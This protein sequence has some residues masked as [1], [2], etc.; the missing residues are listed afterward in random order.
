MKKSALYLVFILL[1]VSL[2]TFA[3]AKI[4]I[5]STPQEMY[6]LGDD[7]YI[8]VTTIPASN[9]GNL[10]VNLNCDNL[11]TNIL[12]WPVAY[13]G[14]QYEY[15]LPVKT[16][17]K[18]DMEVDSVEE[19]IGNCHISATLG[20]EQDSTNNFV[21]TRDILIDASLNKVKYNP[22]EKITL[23][24]TAKKANGDYLNGVLAVSGATSFKKAVAEGQAIDSFTLPETTEA[25][26]YELELFVYDT[27]RGEVIMNSGN[28]SLLFSINQIADFIEVVLSDIEA[29]PGNDFSFSTNIYDQSGKQMDG[30]VNVLASSSN[31]EEFQTTLQSGS[32][33][34]VKLPFNATSGTW[35]IRASLKDIVEEREFS[36]K[37]VQKVY[38]EFLDSI[39]IVKNI[40]NDIYNKT[41]EVRIGDKLESLDV[42]ILPGEER[43]FNLKAPKGEYVVLV[44]DGNDSLEKSLLLTGGAV[45]IDNVGALGWFNKYPTL[46]L[47]IIFILCVVTGFFLYKYKRRTVKSI[48][49]NDEEEVGDTKKPNKTKKI[50]ID[51]N[52][53]KL[54][55]AEANAAMKG[56]KAK[57]TVVSLKLS[58]YNDFK[59]PTKQEFDKILSSCVKGTKGMVDFRGEY[60]FI[61]YS[62]V[63]TK[64]F[65]NEKTAAKVAFE[66]L[67]KMTEYNRKFAEKMEFN[68]GMNS[69]DL[70]TSLD[71]K[72]KLEYTSVG[73]TILL[74]KRI[75]DLGKAK[76]FVSE[77]VKL[78][79]GREFKF[80]K[81][82]VLGKNNIYSVEDMQD[83]RLDN[84]KLANIL[85]RIER[86]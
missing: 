40:G 3:S 1:L 42:N 7:I 10:N 82:G 54:G 86:D 51:I 33:G 47:V 85:K 52:K 30:V 27:D 59:E 57:S 46:W 77:D 20:D 73:N 48:E 6:N 15:Q 62:P 34:S 26:D 49:D 80:E 35:K 61:V 69:G 79:L 70:I 56:D 63:V 28:R 21:V 25:G 65:E 41:I 24:V 4:S 18:E 71:K 75:S 23:T 2:M 68:I 78:R 43:K 32:S 19:I 14:E 36:V 84:E 31:E 45:S 16:L 76:M 22:G 74:A 58:N 83:K 8:T 64:T 72:G 81:H 39:L 50:M 11:S 44:N 5:D 29:E 12:K 13:F 55:E 9:Y 38:F 66:L 37:S 67:N 53:L 17:N 60:I